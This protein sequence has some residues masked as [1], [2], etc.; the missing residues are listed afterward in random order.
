VNLPNAVNSYVEPAKIVDYLLNREHPEGAGKAE[1]FAHFGFTVEA[2]EVLAEA[3]V[4]HARTHQVAS[5]SETRYGVKYRIEGPI[6]CP[7]GR[8]PSIRS[9]WIID[10]GANE[11]RLVT[12]H[13][14]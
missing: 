13:P 6:I 7:D 14:F 12:A 10:A 1:F 8:A 9:V 3:L 5:M 4:I 2:W 11:P